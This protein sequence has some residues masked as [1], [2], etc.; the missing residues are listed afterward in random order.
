MVFKRGQKIE[1]FQASRDEAWEAYMDDFV[2]AHGVV[3]DPDSYINDPDALIAVS[4]GNP[5]TDRLGRRLKLPRQLFRRPTG[6]RQLNHLLAKLNRIGRFPSR[7]RG[8]LSRK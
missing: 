1:V 4:L 7:H 5:V 8:L 3:T 2:G 6:T